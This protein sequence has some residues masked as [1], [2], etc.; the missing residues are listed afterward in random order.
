MFL[1]FHFYT[2]KSFNIGYVTLYKENKDYNYYYYYYYYYKRV[3]ADVSI[4]KRNF[5][6]LVILI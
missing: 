3:S 1:F 5:S 6:K 2:F 4:S